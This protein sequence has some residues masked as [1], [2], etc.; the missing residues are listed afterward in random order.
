MKSAVVL[1]NMGGA[2]SKKELKE[3][4]LNMFSD[5]RIIASNIRKI[6]APLI[7]YSRCNRVWQ[8]YELIGGSKIYDHTDS[9]VKKI[10]LLAKDDY[11]IFYAMKYT[12]PTISELLEE[13]NYDRVFLFP[14][15]PQKSS[16]TTL[17]SF[18][19]ADIFFEAKN[20][21][22]IKINSFFE[23]IDFN[24]LII[25]QIKKNYIQDSELIFSAHGLPVSIAKKDTYE[26]HIKKHI[27]ILSSLL[28]EK[29]LKF[30][31]I[32]L[33]YQS[34]IKPFKW[35]EPSLKDLLKSLKSNSKII[36]YPISFTIDNSETDF[37][38]AIE[39]KHLAS[40]LGL[41]YKL[42]KPQNDSDEFA[43]YIHNKIKAL[44]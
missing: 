2:R 5:P 24:K 44:M 6:L 12:K 33:A 30:N 20:T 15:Y 4:L 14:L 21:Q 35:L 27:E 3:F 17:A 1:L 42:C 11:D 43:Q 7:T 39:Y 22:V 13:T 41:Q 29:G 19:D 26:G 8:N 31:K 38:L 18:D 36:I 16:T 9:L 32:H 25:N 10:A 34:S 23:D 37:E 40:N 28:E